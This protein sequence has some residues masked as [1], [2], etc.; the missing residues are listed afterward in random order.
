VTYRNVRIT[1]EVANSWGGINV[2][3]TTYVINQK[4]KVVKRYVGA[5]P[6]QIERMKADI[7]GL[8]AAAPASSEKG[9]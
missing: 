7:E 5:T 8:F 6:E 4:G 3:P 9:K 2:L 1:P